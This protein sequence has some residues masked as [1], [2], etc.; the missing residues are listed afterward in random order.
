M[1]KRNSGECSVQ[2]NQF[3][4]ISIKVNIYGYKKRMLLVGNWAIKK[5]IKSGDKNARQ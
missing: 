1:T 3:I 2:M 5:I 4:K